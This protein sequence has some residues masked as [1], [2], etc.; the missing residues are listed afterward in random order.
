MECT[1]KRV[2]MREANYKENKES[3]RIPPLL[4]KLNHTM[5][6][7]EEYSAVLK[8]IFG[9]NIGENSYVAAPLSGAALENL[10]IGS[11][12]YINSNLLAMSRGGITI[13][14][15]VQI[16]GNVSL[17]SNN[18]DV[19]DRQVLLCKPIV[20]RKGAWIGANSVVLAGVE[21]GKYA[22]VG[23]GAVVTKDVPDYA[24][25]VGNPAKVIKMLEKEKFEKE[26]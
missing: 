12:V 8:E 7:T 18:H 1:E 26:R 6:M 19:Y 14:D 24:V 9:E 22:I 17:L 13:E 3:Q 5:P 16:A 4:F 2:D 23:A 21:I 10:R 11:N 15:D 20:I 25:V